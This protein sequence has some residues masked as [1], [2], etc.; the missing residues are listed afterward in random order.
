MKCHSE[1]FAVIL[2]EAKDLALGAQG[3]LRE[4][5]CSASGRPPRKDQGEIPRFARNDSAFQSR[6]MQCFSAEQDRDL[7]SWQSFLDMLLES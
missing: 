7:L 5:S 6:A 1:P 2:S 3:K 4:E